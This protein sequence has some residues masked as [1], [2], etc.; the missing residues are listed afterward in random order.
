MD[1]SCLARMWFSLLVSCPFSDHSTVAR[2]IDHIGAM[3]TSLE[4]QGLSDEKYFPETRGT[5]V[6]KIKQEI[7]SGILWNKGGNLAH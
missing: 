1:Q 4:S 6:C 7:T 3:K 5:R 2:D